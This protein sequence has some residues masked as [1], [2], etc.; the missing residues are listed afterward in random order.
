MTPSGALRA[1]AGSF[2]PDVSCPDDRPP[3]L[4]LRFL[5]SA[6][7]LWGLLIAGRRNFLAE[8]DELLLQ[9]RI[10]QRR[11][12]CSIQLGDDVL[13]RALGDPHPMPN[14]QVE[15]WHASLVHS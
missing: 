1:E 15:A 5:I 4:G 7:R 3:L 10:C 13:R 6:Q 14:R 8:V 9:V 11:H 12:D 2:S